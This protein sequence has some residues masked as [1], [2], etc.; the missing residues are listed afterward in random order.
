[1]Y[2]AKNGVSS[3]LDLDQDVRDGVEENFYMLGGQSIGY[4]IFAICI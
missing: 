2:I 1:M 4:A 3:G